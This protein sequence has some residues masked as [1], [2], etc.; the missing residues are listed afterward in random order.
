MVVV[1][2]LPPITLVSGPAR[3]GKSRWA[4]HLVQ[5]SGSEVIYVAT[6]PQCPDDPD[7][8][9]RLR[10]HRQR[11][12]ETW[13]LW[14]VGGELT[15]AIEQLMPHQVAL[16]DSLGTWVAAHLEAEPAQWVQLVHELVAATQV[17][18][19]HLVLVAEECG[20]GV[21]PSTALGGRFRDRLGLVQQHLAAVADASW[22]V[23]QGRALPLHALSLPVPGDP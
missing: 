6:G 14:E 3:S 16:V 9:D 15:A 10:R 13:E 21:V 23:I 19:G 22:L 18:A 7:W 5:R 1:E 20:W 8:Q 2:P 12:P 17:A 11:R 4:E